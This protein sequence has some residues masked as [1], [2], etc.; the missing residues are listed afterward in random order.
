MLALIWS[1]SYFYFIIIT[2]TKLFLYHNYYLEKYVWIQYD[3]YNMLFPAQCYVPLLR[4]MD[5]TMPAK[6]GEPWSPDRGA[7]VPSQI[8]VIVSS[9]P[10]DPALVV[11]A[12]AGPMSPK[13][14]SGAKLSSH[15]AKKTF[16]TQPLKYTVCFVIF[17]AKVFRKKWLTPPSPSPKDVRKYNEVRCSDSEK[18][19][20]RIGRFVFGLNVKYHPI[21]QLSCLNSSAVVISLEETVWLCRKLAK[22][23]GI[24]WQEYW[25]FLGGFT[26]LADEDGLHQL[27]HYLGEKYENL[28]SRGHLDEEMEELEAKLRAFHVTSP[29]S[30]DSPHDPDNSHHAILRAIYQ[31]HYTQTP[32]SAEPAPL[33]ASPMF[34]NI[35]HAEPV[36]RK[37]NVKSF[38][39]FD[40]GDPVLDPGNNNK[41]SSQVVIDRNEINVYNVD[42]DENEQFSDCREEPENEDDKNEFDITLISGRRRQHLDSMSSVDSDCDSYYTAAQ[43]GA[44][45]SIKDEDEDTSVDD[46]FPSDMNIF[47]FG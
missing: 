40:F 18:G 2:L 42:A 23:L 3:V 47:I 20:E 5:N 46:N 24:P 25:E 12:F 35:V 39:A 43:S 30:P 38:K 19:L 7:P 4:S 16:Y 6:V 22:T 13:Q 27:E 31:E 36:S 32:S 9:S 45:L 37:D 15:W 21:A 14:V 33:G 44:A 17:Q 26:D 29:Q 1:L 28:L 10:K 11:K 34:K 41:H 8:G